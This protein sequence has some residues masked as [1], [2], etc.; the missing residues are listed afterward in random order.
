M[1]HTKILQYQFATSLKKI[2][3]NIIMF[4]LKKLNKLSTSTYSARGDAANAVPVGLNREEA[5]HSA[6]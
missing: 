5:I 4:L 6:S 3:P 1:E 2:L